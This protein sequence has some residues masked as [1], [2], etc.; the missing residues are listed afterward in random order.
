MNNA[1]ASM[2]FVVARTDN[3]ID[4]E[5]GLFARHGKKRTVDR[6]T[7]SGGP[8]LFDGGKRLGLAGHLRQGG[9]SVK[10]GMEQSMA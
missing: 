3:L 6:D 9:L 7:A 10:I 1:G 2:L 8:G 5:N 4:A